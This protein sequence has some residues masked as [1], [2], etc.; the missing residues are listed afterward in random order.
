VLLP[1]VIHSHELLDELKSIY[2]ERMEVENAN[3]LCHVSFF[4]DDIGSIY[5]I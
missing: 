1:K 4:V 3:T 5:E 2:N